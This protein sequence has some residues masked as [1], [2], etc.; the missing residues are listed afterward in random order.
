MLQAFSSSAHLV[1][2]LGGE[3]RLA[4]SE[5]LWSHL[6]KFIF[7]QEIQ[8]MFQSHGA[9]RGKDDVFIFARGTQIGQFLFFGGVDVDI[10]IAVVFAHDHAF[11]D[12]V[13]RHDEETS[14]RFEIVQGIR[15]G[16]ACA[17]RYQRPGETG[18]KIAAPGS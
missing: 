8:S 15:H 7:P 16:V 12:G 10:I 13:S 14:A 4:Q 18:D 1:A 17:I 2:F 3:F 11:I 9:N 5:R 6:Q